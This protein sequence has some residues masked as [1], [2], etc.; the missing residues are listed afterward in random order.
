MYEKPESELAQGE[1]EMEKYPEDNQKY[2]YN[3]YNEGG[4]QDQYNNNNNEMQNNILIDHENNDLG[5]NQA[6]YPQGT[7]EEVSPQDSQRIEEQEKINHEIFKGFLVKIYGILSAQLIITLFFILL[8]QKE[9][10]KQYFLKNIGISSFLNLLSAL[11]FILTLVIISINPNLGRKVPLNYL[12]LFIITICMSLMLALFAINYSFPIVV[13]CVLLTIVSS[14]SITVYA[15]NTT[16]DWRYV[17]GLC[18]VI[19]SQCIGFILM[20]FILSI[21]FLEMVCCF[22][23]TLLFGVYLV[24]DTQVIMGKYG[25]VYSLDDYIY[26][27]LEIYLDI[28]R[29]FMV[30]LSAIGKQRK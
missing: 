25:E 5:V 29:L 12:S 10:I 18:V 17:R 4:F 16:T 3:N 30:I 15:Y 9:S 27:S 20:V 2:N 13:F 28:A 24:Y 7:K 14:V 8:F 21:T 26:A 19:L 23:F 6:Q 22:F 1:N 11:L